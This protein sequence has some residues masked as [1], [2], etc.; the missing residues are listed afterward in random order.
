MA[1]NL[2]VL[3]MLARPLALGVLRLSTE[4]RPGDAD[5]VAVVQH[6]LDAGVRVLDTA[7]V[8]CD[9]QGRGA[10]DLHYGERLVR[11]AIES[12]HGPRDEVRVLTKAGLS[13]P[14]GRW[15]PNGRPE[16]LRRTVE[17]SCQALGVERLFVLQLH[18]HD[19]RVPFEET[20]GALAELQRAGLVEHLGLCNTSVAEAQQAQRH[21]AIALVQNELSVF[22]R[23]SAGDGLLAWTAQ[24]AIPFLA[25]RPLGG[26]ASARKFARH[27][28]LGPLAARHQCS[29]QQMALAAVLAS[30]PHVLPLVGATRAESIA[31]S[32]AALEIGF[33]VSDQLALELGGCSFAPKTA[34]WPVPAPPLPASLTSPGL[35]A[36]QG[37][38]P[39]DEVVVLM[40]I[41]GAGKSELVEE[42][43]RHGYVRL[44][45]DALGGRLEDLVPRLAGLLASGQR[46]VVLDNTY[47]TR[48]SRAPVITAARLVG[49]PVRCRWVDIPLVEAQRNI[50]LRMLAKYGRPLGPEELK[51]LRKSDP[52][53]P[54]PAALAMW[55]SSFE[56]P[57]LDEGFAAVDVIPFVRRPNPAAVE[58]GLLLDVD[59]T[60]RRTRSGELYPRTPDDIEILPGR[61]ETLARWVD[62]GYRLCFVSNQSGVATGQLSRAMC[63][64]GLLRTAE[65][66]RVQITEVAYCPHPAHPVSCFCR[67]PLPGLGVYLME[68]QRLDPSRLIMVGD[69]DSD[70]QFAAGLGARYYEADTFFSLRGPRP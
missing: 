35:P 10:A 2:G 64:A 55:M 8:Y 36:Q 39:S 19:P 37:P 46:R 52:N 63:E 11:T 40:G 28:I 58:R 60:L 1:R 48:L 25:Y 54:P 20:L 42:Y 50:V 65:L 67:K 57:A 7:D 6:A 41:Q 69:M 16:H 12:W 22:Q 66:L 26:V 59:G 70:A 53:L 51:A 17:A 5:A 24:Q 49:V 47:P 4:G 13:R 56:R 38:G 23:K 15:I 68:R 44:N 29:P 33:D 9:V 34:A 43:V 3:G 31:S 62:A 21:F 27:R 32:V 45:R 61:R 14:Q 30:G 18:V